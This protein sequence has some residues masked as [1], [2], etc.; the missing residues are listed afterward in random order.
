[1]PK[2]DMAERGTFSEG[3]VPSFSRKASRNRVF[4]SMAGIIPQ[5][6]HNFCLYLEL[7]C[8]DIDKYRDADYDS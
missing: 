4:R 6:W 1:M 3:D 8:A 5:S 2:L 7:E